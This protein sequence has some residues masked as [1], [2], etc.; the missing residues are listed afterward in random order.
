MLGLIAIR[1]D[2]VVPSMIAHAINNAAAIAMSRGELP[3]LA[4]WVNAH[5]APV[6]A[7]CVAVT[8]LGIAAVLRGRA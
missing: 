7:G 5:P 8:A 1:A 4:G 2:S 6:L 3:G